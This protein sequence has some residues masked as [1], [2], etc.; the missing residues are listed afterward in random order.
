[1]AAQKIVIISDLAAEGVASK[2]YVER[3][4][5][6]EIGERKTAGN[7]TSDEAK[8]LKATL[9]DLRLMFVEESNAPAEVPKPEAP[10][11]SSEPTD[12][13]KVKFHKKYE[14]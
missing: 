10:A 13:S 4:K 11:E 6:P 7:L 2:P 1:M 9:T 12:E 5:R 8:V 14:A 3:K